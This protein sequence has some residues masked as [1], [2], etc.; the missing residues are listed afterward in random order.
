[1][2]RDTFGF[3]FWFVSLQTPTPLCRSS[4]SPRNQSQCVTLLILPGTKHSSSM[5]WRSLATPRSPWSL[6]PTSLWSFTIRTLM[7]VFKVCISIFIWGVSEAW[8]FLTKKMKCRF[9]ICKDCVHLC[10]LNVQGADEFMGR[11]VCQ[12]SMTHSPRLAWFP[13]RWGDKYAGELLAA[14]ELIRREKVED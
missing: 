5:R 14:F 10:V 11:C 4:I 9:Q 3:M 13:I 12:P 8:N 7:W 1:M 2:I 6:H